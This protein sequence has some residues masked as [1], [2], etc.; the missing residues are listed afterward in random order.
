MMNLDHTNCTS[1]RMARSIPA[2]GMSSRLQFIYPRTLTS[3]A[4]MAKFLRR[5]YDNNDDLDA[6]PTMI[7]DTQWRRMRQPVSLEARRDGAEVTS[8]PRTTC[9][10]TSVLEAAYGLGRRFS[11]SDIL[12]RGLSIAA[13][14]PPSRINT[15]DIRNEPTQTVA[16]YPHRLH[17]RQRRILWREALLHNTAKTSNNRRDNDIT[18]IPPPSRANSPVATNARQV[19]ST[20]DELLNEGIEDIY[21]T[22]TLPQPESNRDDDD[23]DNAKRKIEEKQD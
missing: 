6:L 17:R 16:S 23:K 10:E 5:P 2:D 3:T 15:M 19:A 14:R 13:A 1:N 21:Q 12:E 4:D 18:N 20:L 7:N 8:I 11:M 22:K 9:T